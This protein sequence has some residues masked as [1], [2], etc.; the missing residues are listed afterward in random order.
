MLGEPCGCGFPGL[1]KMG[2]PLDVQRPWPRRDT[3]F[4]RRP[5]ALGQGDGVEHE[6][7]KAGG[8]RSPVPG[9]S[10]SDPAPWAPSSTG[11]KLPLPTRRIALRC[12]ILHTLRGCGAFGLSAGGLRILL[13]HGREVMSSVLVVPHVLR[14]R[15]ATNDCS[16][17]EFF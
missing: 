1:G 16:Q 4:F 15:P 10:R 9:R 8:S 2:A 3:T 5:A 14:H 12:G 7:I 11:A 17:I 13:V 6:R